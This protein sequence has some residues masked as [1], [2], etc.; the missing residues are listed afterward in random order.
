MAA[1]GGPPQGDLFG[2]AVESRLARQRPLAA[3]MRPESLDEV[4]GQRALL[5]PDGALRRAIEGDRVPSMILYGPPGSGKTTLARVV[6]QGTAA[7]FEELS[8][9]SATVADVRA[10]MARARDRLAAGT[11]TVLFL[12]EI[13]RFNR[14]QQDALLPAVEDGLITLI[15]ATTQNPWYEVNAALVSRMRVWVLEPLEPD[16]VAALIDRAVADPRGVAGRVR[17][18]AEARAAIV[19]RAGGDAR[20][21]LNLLEAA[22]AGTPDGEDIALEAV[23]AAAGGR[24]VVYDR[25][26][27]AHYDT[28]SAFIKSLRGSDPDAAIYYLAVM[29][30]GGE[31]PK[32]IARRLIMAASE[33][34][35]NADPRALEVA[36]AAGRAVEFVGLPEARIALAQAT[37]NIALAPKSNASYRAIG[38]ALAHVEREGAHRPP[39]ALRDSSAANARGLGHGEGYAYPHDHPDGV[40]DESLLPE[41]MEGVSFYAPTGRGPEGELAA[42]LRELRA[43]LREDEH[44]F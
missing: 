18:G 42:R 43:R 7:A 14:A 17:L 40:L 22:A 27:D 16:D 15:G 23:Q 32:F 3:R 34:V 12:D 19:A 37:T 5:G 20:G 28:I 35:G 31:D 25:Q 1:R 2:E 9:V 36:V 11:R 26:G 38:A 33:D 21:A 13:H 30:S 24:A 4:V 44:P 29:L 6:A 41:G 39:P 10:V 8:A